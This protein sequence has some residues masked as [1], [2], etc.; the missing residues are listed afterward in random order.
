MSRSGLRKMLSELG[1]R[2]KGLNRDLTSDERLY[3]S[4]EDKQDW[5]EARRRLP[6]VPQTPV[7]PSQVVLRCY[8]EAQIPQGRGDRQGALPGRAGA[9]WVTHLRKMGEQIDRDP[10]EPVWVT[11]GL[12]EPC[13]FL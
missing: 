12:G 6:I 13:G 9:V 3:S 11:Q 1:S 8:R 7:D 2:L 10:A 5:V 4:R